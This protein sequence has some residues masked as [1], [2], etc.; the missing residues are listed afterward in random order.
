MSLP[1]GHSQSTSRSPK[2]VALMMIYK[3]FQLYRYRCGEEWCRRE[4]AN[5]IPSH[6]FF[7]HIPTI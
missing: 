2:K 7:H 4:S 1:K 6:A 3:K 5:A